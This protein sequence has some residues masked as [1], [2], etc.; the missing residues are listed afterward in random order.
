MKA[1]FLS[2]MMLLL[3]TLS[4]A[5][6]VSVYAFREGE[7]VKG[8][9]YFADGSP[10]KKVK[11]ELYDEKGVKVGE[12]LTDEKGLFSIKTQEKG[13][14]KV[15]A[16]AGPEHRAQYEIEASQ[17]KE[18]KANQGPF[19]INDNKALEER[20]QALENE[21]RDLRKAMDH[22]TF[23]DIIGGIGYIFGVWGIINL[24]LRRKH[25]S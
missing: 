18:A 17:E 25:A 10:C 22:L 21:L 24:F 20:L 6:K 7:T 16:L 13:K 4:L 9:C 15:L 19:Q 12:G 1:F 3:P 5:H 23:R 2:L 14:L 11:V 8:E